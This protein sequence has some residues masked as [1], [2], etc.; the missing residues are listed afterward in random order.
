MITECWSDHI[1]QFSTHVV[2]LEAFL[3]ALH[4]VRTVTGKTEQSP[5]V[6]S[7][8]KR[9]DEETRGNDSTGHPFILSLHLVYLFHNRFDAGRLSVGRE[10]G[11]LRNIL[12]TFHRATLEFQVNLEQKD[13]PRFL[14]THHTNLASGLNQIKTC[15]SFPSPAGRW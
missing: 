8:M 5:P 10:G 6:P 14:M 7:Q 3:T 9:R 15:R 4:H 2:M 11:V 12:R 13:R 1:P